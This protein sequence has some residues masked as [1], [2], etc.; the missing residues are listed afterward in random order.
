MARGWCRED[1]IL[2]DQKLLDAIGR[3]DFGNQLD[4]LRIPV[5][6]I[7]TDDKKGALTLAVSNWFPILIP[8]TSSSPQLTFNALWDGQQDACDKGFAIMRLLEHGDLFAKPRAA[9][10]TCVSVLVPPK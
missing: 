10:V 6:A 3:A 8:P 7:A 1:S 4:H 5:P 9:S 2:S